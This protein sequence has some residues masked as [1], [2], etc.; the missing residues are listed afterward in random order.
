MS[1]LPGVT[2]Q[3]APVAVGTVAPK[4]LNDEI[5]RLVDTT[6]TVVLFSP[7]DETAL[8]LINDIAQRIHNYPTIA[9]RYGLTLEAMVAWIRQPEVRR[10]IKLRR[11]CWESDDNV[12]ERN[13]TLYG[14]LVMDA[15]PAIDALLHDGSVPH[16]AKLDAFKIVGRFAGLDSPIKAPQG[17]TEGGTTGT[18]FAVNIHFSGGETARVTLAQ[19]DQVSA[20]PLDDAA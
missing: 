11:A 7:D 10:R 1:D 4:N 15:A 19:P 9:E 20:L 3:T 5:D 8:R 14:H 13:R 2:A 16:T 18:H 17:G 6:P 12:L